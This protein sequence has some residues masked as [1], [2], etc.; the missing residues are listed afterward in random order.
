VS[1]LQHLRLWSIASPIS[2][3][4]G[5]AGAQ[6]AQPLLQFDDPASEC[7]HYARPRAPVAS[8]QSIDLALDS[9]QHIDVL[10]RLDCD[11][12]IVDLR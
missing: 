3:C 7:A 4:F 8:C 5:D 1:A 12:R 9:E 6:L 10:D 2:L 11:W